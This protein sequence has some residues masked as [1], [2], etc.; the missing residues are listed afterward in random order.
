MPQYGPSVPGYPQQP[1]TGHSPAVP[2]YPPPQNTGYPP[3]G[4]NPDGPA[5]SYNSGTNPT[6]VVEI[7]PTGYPTGNARPPDG[8]SSDGSHRRDSGDAFSSS[9]SD[10]AIRHGKN[11]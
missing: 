11:I 1:G 5:V 6:I 9:F 10:K 7:P 2:Y 3:S 4:Y 8:E